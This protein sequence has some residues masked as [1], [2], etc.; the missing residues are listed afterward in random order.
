MVEYVFFFKLEENCQK[1]Q[2]LMLYIAIVP[3]CIY[4]MPLLEISNELWLEKYNKELQRF[5]HHICVAGPL[6]FYKTER[7]AN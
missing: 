1:I 7:G 2:L 6:T 4:M 3:I 5:Q